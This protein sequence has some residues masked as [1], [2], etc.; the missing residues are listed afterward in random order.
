MHL[1]LREK[2]AATI[3]EKNAFELKSLLEKHR[4]PGLDCVVCGLPLVNFTRA[5]RASLL[6]DI[7]ASL[8]PG[9]L[10]IAFQYTR[11]L[12]PL[13]LATYGKIECRFVWANLPPA[14][15]F[16]CRK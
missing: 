15:V 3:M 16:V 1:A 11:R 4:L 13:L 12:R 2:F 9:G 10:F 14:Y 8:N 7:H 5:E 6:S